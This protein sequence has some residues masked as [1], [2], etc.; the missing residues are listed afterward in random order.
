MCLGL[1]KE[2]PVVGQ[3]SFKLTSFSVPVFFFFPFLSGVL[4][5]M[6]PWKT[7][8]CSIVPRT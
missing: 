5:G 7:P 8:F 3:A 4:E 2:I 6:D 1:A